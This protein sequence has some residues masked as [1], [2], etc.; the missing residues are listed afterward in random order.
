MNKELRS[1][2]LKAIDKPVVLLIEEHSQMSSSKLYKIY[3]L[4]CSQN[5]TTLCNL[6]LFESVRQ[7]FLKTN[8]QYKSFTPESVFADMKYKFYHNLKIILT[9]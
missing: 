3:E 2:L 4:L 9:I 1:V 6:E 8:D 7:Q 5:S